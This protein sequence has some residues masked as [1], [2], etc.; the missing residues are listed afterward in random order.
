MRAELV[1]RAACR[2]VEIMDISVLGCGRWG[3]FLAYYLSDLHNITLWGRPDSRHIKEL[4]ETRKNEYLT[5]KDN[6]SV[7]T[8]LSVAMKNEVV[9]ISI[10]T[11]EMGNLMEQLSAF[12][13]NTHKFVLCMKGIESETGKRISEIMIERGVDPNNIALWVGPGH[14]QNFL[15]GTPNCMI[16]HSYDIKLA[17]RLVREFSSPLIR[18]YV[19]NDIIGGE[20]GSAGKNV[21]GIAAG[22]LDGIGMSCLK[23]ALMSRGTYEIAKLI[24]AMG[25]RVMTAYGLSHLGDFE[26]T[27]FSPYSHNRM[28]GELY[29]KG[30]HYGKSAEGVGNVKGI[31]QL[32]HKHNI[33]MPITN[34]LYNI[35]YNNADYKNE[36]RNLFLRDTKEEFV[37]F[38]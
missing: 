19:G 22:V 32:A 21:F 33:S 3:T 34:A 13:L 4:Q 36:F 31:M 2:K 29:V 24:Q 25:G 15:Q 6:I 18:F 8:D 14:V 11:Q 38:V 12:D 17:K 37:E 27:L 16:I 10:L 30:E 23:G 26:A 28:W 1:G 5:L 9:V 35:I 7:E 20:I